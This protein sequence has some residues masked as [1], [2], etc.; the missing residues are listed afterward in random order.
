MTEDEENEKLAIDQYFENDFTTPAEYDE[1]GYDSENSD[2]SSTGSP[3]GAAEKPVYKSMYE[4]LVEYLAETSISQTFQRRSNAKTLLFVET[5]GETEFRG[6]MTVV[7]VE[8][9]DYNPVNELG[10]CLYITHIMTS[11]RRGGF[12]KTTLRRILDDTVNLK[13][14]Y[15]ESIMSDRVE[16]SFV[17]SGWKKAGRGNSVYII[18]IEPQEPRGKK[19]KLDSTVGGK[20]RK[21]RKSRKSRKRRKS[22]KSKKVARLLRNRSGSRRR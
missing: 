19:R 9:N 5:V 2:N 16:Q 11:P 20:I 6:M 8:A 3:D 4:T 17:E 15:V 10:E 22:R 21:S 14:V 18:K 1:S 7:Y 13:S 12:F